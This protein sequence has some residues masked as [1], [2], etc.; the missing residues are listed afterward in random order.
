MA[1]SRSITDE[2][3]S[4]VDDDDRPDVGSTRQV[5]YEDGL[6]FIRKHVFRMPL[7][8][9]VQAAEMFHI[10]DSSLQRS[11]DALLMRTNFVE[12]YL[13]SV[14]SE[15]AASVTH[16]RTIYGRI[17][18]RKSRAEDGLLADDVGEGDSAV[19]FKRASDVTFLEQGINIMR[20]LAHFQT[21]DL[22]EVEQQKA[23][24]K[25]VIQ[26]IKFVRL[27]YEEVVQSFRYNTKGYLKLATR[28]MEVHNLLQA[29]KGK[30]SASQLADE[31]A[32]LHD[33]MAAVEH[34]VCADRAYLWHLCHL[35]ERNYEKQLRLRDTIHQ[36]YLRIVYKE[37]RKHATNEQQVLDNFQNGSTGL[38]RAISCYNLDQNVS[39]SSYAHWWIRQ[40][41]LFHIKDSS[42]FIKLPVTTWQAYTSV[43]KQR[44]KLVASSGDDHLE[45]LSAETGHSQSKLKEIYE[46]V[47]SS[48]VHSLDYE[49][50]ESGKTMLVD[51]I[52]D[53]S[54]ED[55][56]H[57]SDISQDIG[58][59]LSLLDDEQRRCVVLRYGLV[60]ML[61]PRGEITDREII[62]EKIRQRVAAVR[63]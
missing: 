28:A 35:V 10:L 41:I 12:T 13:S 6:E 21:R 25:S 54:I 62:R 24:V 27:V 56:E 2:V 1:P 49:V 44:A 60:K 31:Y 53:Q 22:H 11:V 5:E 42:N 61:E 59:R 16:G 33:Q 39:F 43:E 63:R 9:Q 23:A 47:R 57:Q 58:S 32:T 15:V 26:G 51:V 30:L 38:L 3:R 45:A 50:D 55:A 36:P 40:S 37:A 34:S 4:A 20:M 7:L 52:P 29:A 19:V 14:I 46:S 17:G 8:P 18:N 48:H